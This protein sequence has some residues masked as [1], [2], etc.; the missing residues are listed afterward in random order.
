LSCT[1]RHKLLHVRAMDR[2]QSGL[3]NSFFL[4]AGLRGTWDGF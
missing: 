2:Q 4:T 1:N 3:W